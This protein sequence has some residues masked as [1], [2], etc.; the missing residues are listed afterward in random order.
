MIFGIRNEKPIPVRNLGFR[1]SCTIPSPT[2]CDRNQKPRE[3]KT[4]DDRKPRP[5]L[6]DAPQDATEEADDCREG[7][8]V[9]LANW[10]KHC[11][12]QCEKALP[13]EENPKTIMSS[14]SHQVAFTKLFTSGFS[15]SKKTRLPSFR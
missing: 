13:P 15:P 9:A 3:P 12:W 11:D 1:F 6:H 14:P 2:S 5:A 7:R 4:W 8:H 10:Q